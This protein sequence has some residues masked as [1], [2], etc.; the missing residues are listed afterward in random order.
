MNTED[1]VKALKREL[2]AARRRRPEDVN[3]IEA[4]LRS[5]GVEAVDG[6]QQAVKKPGRPRKKPEADE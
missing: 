6:V 2:A 3:A 5:L 4:T 1:H